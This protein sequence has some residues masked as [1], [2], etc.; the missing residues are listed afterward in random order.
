MR[1]SGI[2]LPVVKRAKAAGSFVRKV[3]WAGQIAA[4]DRVFAHPERGTVWIEFKA[5]GERPRRSQLL[6]H[7]RMRA[8]GMEVHVCDSVDYALRELGLLGGHNGGPGLW[9]DVV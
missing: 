3:Q 1:E 6:E 7:E 9:S 5:P 8:A 4:P 2:E